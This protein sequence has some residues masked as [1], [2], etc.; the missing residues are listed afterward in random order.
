M[1][2]KISCDPL[3][4]CQLSR[5]D[6]M[7]PLNTCTIFPQGSRGVSG[8]GSEFTQPSVSLFSSFSVWTIQRSAKKFVL[9]SITQ[10]APGRNTHNLEKEFSQSL[11]ILKRNLCFVVNATWA[12]TSVVTLY[13]RCNVL[14]IL[15]YC[16]LV[17]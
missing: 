2:T 8:Q 17:P 13:F 9:L 5:E 14:N 1:F 16:N 7:R 15:K 11:Y 4:L 10:A 3:R 12:T 6:S